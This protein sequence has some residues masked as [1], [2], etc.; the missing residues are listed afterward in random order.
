MGQN[1]LGLYPS[2]VSGNVDIADRVALE[3]V[4]DTHKPTVVINCAGKTGRPN[5][6]WCESHKIETLRSNGTGA[7]ALLVLVQRPAQVST[8]YGPSQCWPEGLVGLH[9]QSREPPWPTL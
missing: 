8:V 2:A 9:E 4:L 3:D 6:D 5:I 1:L 7:L